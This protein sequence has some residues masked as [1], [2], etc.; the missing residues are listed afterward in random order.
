LPPYALAWDMAVSRTTPTGR[1]A[2]L[3]VWFIRSE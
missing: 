1:M 3:G 2:R